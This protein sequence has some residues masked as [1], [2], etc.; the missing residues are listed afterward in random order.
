MDRYSSARP[1]SAGKIIAIGSAT[2]GLVPLTLEGGEVV[3]VPQ[4]FVTQ[5][6]PQVGGYYVAYENGHKMA[7]TA[8]FFESHH[9]KL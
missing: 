3:D 9:T 2:A 7:S 5:Y 1:M 8:A 4:A 6:A